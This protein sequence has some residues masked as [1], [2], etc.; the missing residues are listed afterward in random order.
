[1]LTHSE[2]CFSAFL[3]IRLNWGHQLSLYSRANSRQSGVHFAKRI[4]IPRIFGLGIG[5]LCVTSVLI[6]QAMPVWIWLLLMINGLI[7]P[8]VAYQLSINADFPHRQELINLSI[9]SIL[10][11]TWVA[12]MSF[13]ALPSVVILSMMSMNNIASGGKSLFIKGLLLQISSSLLVFWLF[14]LSFQP[15]TT[16]SQVYSCLPMI[17]IYPSLL[18]WVTFHTAKR[19]VE[20]KEELLRISVRDGL[21][22]LYNRR[23]WEHQLHNQFDSCRRYKHCS[24]LV[25]IDIDQFKTIND[26]YGHTVGDDAITVLAEELLLGLRAIDI[27]G[28]Y[29]GDEF[30]AILPNTTA[31]Q[32]SEVLTRIQGKL[33]E[34][35]FKQSPGLQLKISAGVAEFKPEM[36]N[37]QQW[38]KA[39]DS[40]LYHAKNNGRDRIELAK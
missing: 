22:G 37:Y 34:I 11:G 16:I 1:M 40:A 31:E 12:V 33:A 25:L 24:S 7:W 9:D 5:M 4:Y 29:G 30:G 17:F 8:H 27:V 38:L 23:H 3:K 14:N 21:T 26:T 15:E 35:E 32:A 18:G 6:T 39:V 2:S 19:L 13:N 20:N 28:R 36:A 10:G